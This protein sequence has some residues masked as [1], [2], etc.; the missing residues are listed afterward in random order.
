MHLIVKW[1]TCTVKTPDIRVPSR[2]LFMDIK[3]FYEYRFCNVFVISFIVHVNHERVH[4]SKE[5]ERSV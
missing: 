2:V 3:N 4:D 1:G 5:S